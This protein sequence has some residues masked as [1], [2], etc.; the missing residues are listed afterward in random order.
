MKLLGQG[1]LNPTCRAR[2]FHLMFFSRAGA[3]VSVLWGRFFRVN[4]TPAGSPRRELT[5]FFNCQPTY[6]NKH[7]VNIH[8]LDKNATQRRHLTRNC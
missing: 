8:R 6:S 7:R 1:D 4:V 3:E 2:G 5:K